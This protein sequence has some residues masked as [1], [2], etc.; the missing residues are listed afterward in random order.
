MKRLIQAAIRAVLLA[1]V[2][3]IFNQVGRG[4]R[5]RLALVAD[6]FTKPLGLTHAGD[7]SG[8]L[9]VLEKK[10]LV[11]IIDGETVLPWPYLDLSR[12]VS[13][14]SELGLLGLAFDPDY[15]TDG[16]L[17]VYYTNHAEQSVLARFHV[18][19]DDPNMVDPDSEELILWVKQPTG[20]H[21]GGQ[22]AFGPDGYLYMGLGDGGDE[23]AYE[24]G[25]DLTTLFGKLLRIDVTHVEARGGASYTIPPDNPFVHDPRARHEIWAYGLRNPWRFSFDR[26]TEDLYLADVGQ[27]DYE[28]LNYLPASNP[29]GVNFGWDVME[30]RHCYHPPENCD[31]EGLTLPVI[32]YTH[33]QGNGIIGGFVYRGEASPALQGLYL[34]GDFGN[35]RIWGTSQARGWAFIELLDWNM[36]ISS[37]GEDEAGELY[38][39]DY[40]QG[41]VYHIL[42]SQG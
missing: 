40:H 1:S 2:L 7:N 4:V 32:E 39:L 16:L 22:L 8:R 21:N 41:A 14:R 15:E 28:E 26:A 29:G 18:S 36:A 6:G 34:F 33:K 24:N 19:E 37:F 31:Q 20:N 12:K 10:G 38:V 27:H 23:V 9:F 30:G 17:Y 42:A 11:K 25:Q 35:G 13:T 3:F 5:I